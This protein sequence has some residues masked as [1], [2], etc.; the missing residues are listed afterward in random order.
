MRV[1]VKRPAV[2][3]PAEVYMDGVRVPTL[4][5][6]IDVSNGYRF[7]GA[8][9]GG[10]LKVDYAHANTDRKYAQTSREIEYLREVIA[11]ADLQYFPTLLDWGTTNLG[12]AWM[13]TTL[14]D[15]DTDS[16]ETFNMDN[17]DTFD[18]LLEQ[19]EFKDLYINVYLVGSH[20][21]GQR[22]DGT[23]VIWDF[24]QGFPDKV[25]PKAMHA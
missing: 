25:A 5:Q 16:E 4:R 21:A 24:G 12:T 19:Y 7:V 6:D 22:T 10:V 18:R 20:G 13:L 17:S 3:G 1:T 8:W 23:L 15:I 14:E 9:Q 2:Y 11:D